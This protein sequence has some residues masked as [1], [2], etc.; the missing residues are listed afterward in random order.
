MNE[1]K[2]YVDGIAI[3]NP[4]NNALAVPVENNAIQELEVISGT[5]NAEYGQAQS[6]IVNIVTKE[7]TDKFTGSL[8]AYFGD[9][10]SKHTD[11]FWNIDDARSV[12]DEPIRPETETGPPPPRIFSNTELNPGI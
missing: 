5:F 10:Y 4:F 1:I 11:I 8:S 3:S 7:G 9:F 12:R 6:G 2:Y